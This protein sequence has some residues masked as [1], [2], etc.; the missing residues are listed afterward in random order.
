MYKPFLAALA[1]CLAA[2]V[3]AQQAPLTEQPAQAPSAQSDGPVAASV[4]ELPAVPPPAPT[5]AAPEPAVGVPQALVSS[6]TANVV[7]AP[8]KDRDPVVSVQ[9]VK[10]L[11]YERNK[12]QIELEKRKKAEMDRLKEKQK[13][14]D[15]DAMAKQIEKN[16]SLQGIVGD[17][18][19][20]Q[21]KFYSAGQT[22][23]S[24]TK[25]LRIDAD[26]V[27]F[28]HGKRVFIKKVAL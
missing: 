19:I 18:V 13:R 15:P 5:E 3:F 27:T 21:G 26:S 12:V 28:R 4:P 11:E 2:P 23:P 6:N 14:E 9:D 7:F 24:N 16:L 20:I 17:Q 22:L 10:D 8:N 25:I 1:L